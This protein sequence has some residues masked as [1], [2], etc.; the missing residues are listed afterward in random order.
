MIRK[1]VNEP[2]HPKDNAKIVFTTVSVIV[3]Y[4]YISNSTFFI[5]SNNYNNFIS[6]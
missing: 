2:K 1:Q 3:Y 5:I 4:D 6:L